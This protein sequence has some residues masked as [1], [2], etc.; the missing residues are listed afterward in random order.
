LDLRSNIFRAPSNADT[1]TWRVLVGET[2]NTTYTEGRSIDDAEQISGYLYAANNFGNQF[3][4]IDSR[5]WITSDVAITSC[6]WGSAGRVLILQNLIASLYNLMQN[7]W[8]GMVLRNQ[9]SVTGYRFMGENNEAGYVWAPGDTATASAVDQGLQFAWTLLQSSWGLGTT[10]TTVA[11]SDKPII[12]L[13]TASPLPT[14]AS[15]S[16]APT[17]T[18][19][20]PVI[21]S[22]SS[23]VS[24]S[25]VVSLSPLKANQGSSVTIYGSS[26]TQGATCRFT[27]DDSDEIQDQPASCV[28]DSCTCTVPLFFSLQDALLWVDIVDSN[29]TLIASPSGRLSFV[30]IDQEKYELILSFSD[31]SVT[32]DVF[33]G[34]VNALQAQMI[35]GTDLVSNDQSSTVLTSTFDSNP[36]RYALVTKNTYQIVDQPQKIVFVEFTTPQQ[37][38]P[39]TYGH[40][41][42]LSI[43]GS[44]FV[45]TASLEQST[46]T[47]YLVYNTSTTTFSQVSCN[48]QDQVT[49]RLSLQVIDSTTI[50]TNLNTSNLSPVC[51]LDLKTSTKVDNSP[52]TIGISQSNIVYTSSSRRVRQSTTSTTNTLSVT[53][54]GVAM[55]CHGVCSTSTGMNYLPLIIILSVAGGIA[56]AS[57]IIVIAILCIRKM[58]KQQQPPAQVV[59]TDIIDPYARIKSP[60]SPGSPLPPSEMENGLVVDTKGVYHQVKVTSAMTPVEQPGTF[61]VL[62]S[63]ITPATPVTPTESFTNNV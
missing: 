31:P 39:S 49:Y 40:I 20:E 51:S 45:A 14:A 35:V 21:I 23:P 38:T 19:S 5:K 57:I 37:Q 48:Y 12:D 34:D 42:E 62:M 1:C 53:L 28:S 61:A 33:A 7:G 29:D 11:P 30:Y 26:L 9:A 8:R 52:V 60:M 10:T 17:T 13:P 16:P 22:T 44:S 6:G 55:G 36:T 32:S 18:T 47:L 54:N 4:G 15:T 50:R 63:P 25:V 56:V 24:S 58:R 43:I 59:L 27:S 2:Q 3:W 46:N 41:I